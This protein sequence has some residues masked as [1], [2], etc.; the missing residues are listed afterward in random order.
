MLFERFGGRE[1][2]AEAA[3]THEVASCSIYFGI[4]GRRYGRQLPS[5]FSATHTEYLAAEQ[6]GLR[7]GGLGEGRP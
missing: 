5:R 3:Y 2:D 7:M 1:D 6:R 4:L